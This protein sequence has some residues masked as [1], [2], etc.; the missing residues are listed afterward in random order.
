MKPLNRDEIKGVWASLLLPL[1]NDESID[2]DALKQQ[3]SYLCSSGVDGVY[4]NGTACEF[5][6]QSPEEFERVCEITASTCEAAGTPFQLG[7]SH[8]DTAVMFERVRIALRH[9]PSAIQ[10]ILPDWFPLSDAEISGF[11]DRAADIAKGVG[12]VLYNPPHA[13]RVLTPEEI[14]RLV[15]PVTGIVGV[16]TGGGDAG[17]YAEMRET[18]SKIS[19][20][21]PGHFMAS[22]MRAGAAGSYSNVAC[23]SPRGAVHWYGLMKTDMARAL[24]LESAIG[25]FMARCIH[26]LMAR[27][28]AGFVMDKLMAAAGGWSPAPLDNRVRWPYRFPEKDSVGHVRRC[29]EETIPEIACAN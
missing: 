11:L 19:V 25:V 10:I 2:Y 18:F 26:P 8:M 3:V 22:A 20:F 13:K 7:A 27:G 24:E 14:S 12:I 6:A 1:R 23:L 5:F 21:C 29:A 16:K 17:W 4:S 28:Y 15:L 9:S